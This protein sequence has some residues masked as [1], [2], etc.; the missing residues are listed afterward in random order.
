L[1]VGF[2]E[3][4]ELAEL[5]CQRC[6]DAIDI[7]GKAPLIDTVFLTWAAAAAVGGECAVMHIAAIANCRC[8]G[9]CA[10]GSDPAVSGPR[11][12]RLQILNRPRLN[13]IITHEILILLGDLTPDDV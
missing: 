6:P 2:I 9:L 12:Q 3:Q 1:L 10:R 5:I 13:E 8:I 4:T 7:T 11:G